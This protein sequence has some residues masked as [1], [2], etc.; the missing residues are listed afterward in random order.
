M[1]A[2]EKDFT[3]AVLRG[4]TIIEPS[5]YRLEVTMLPD[6]ELSSDQRRLLAWL[7]RNG[8]VSPS[9]LLAQCELAPREAWAALQRLADRGLV[10]IRDDPD[11]PDGSLVLPVSLSPGKRQTRN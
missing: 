6:E 5:P 4:R 2:F 1:T 8:A 7:D 11:S 9:T 3:M 10:V